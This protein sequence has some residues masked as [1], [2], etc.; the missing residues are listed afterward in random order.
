MINPAQF[1]QRIIAPALHRIGLHSQAAE[2]LLMGTALV[3]SG[4]TY[5]RQIGGGPARGF[6]QIEPATHTDIW[7][8]F[9]SD[10]RRRGL[11]LDVVVLTIANNELILPPHDELEHNLQYAAAIARLVYYRRPEPLPQADDIHDLAA[12]WKR[13]YNTPAGKGNP[14][15]FVRLYHQYAGARSE[16]METI[17]AKRSPKLKEVK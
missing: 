15:D 6:F 13:H 10:R 9:L 2:N 12:Y 14:D 17:A 7:I 16:G 5:L 11:A 3:E 1:R 8:N 4:L